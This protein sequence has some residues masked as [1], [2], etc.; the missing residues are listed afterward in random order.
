M[1]F[2][3]LNGGK[4]FRGI[5]LLE[6]SRLGDHRPEPA[7]QLAAGIELVHGYSLVHDDLPDMDDDDTRRGVEACHV[8]YDPHTAILCGNSLLSLAFDLYVD[9]GFPEPASKFTSPVKLLSKITGHNGVPRGQQKD[10]DFESG[11]PSRDDILRMYRQKTGKL[12]GFSMKIGALNAGLKPQ[13]ANEL[14]NIGEKLGVAYQIADDLLEPL[15]A[16]ERGERAGRSDREN[17][18]KTLLREIGREEAQQ[19]ARS[20]IRGSIDQIEALGLRTAQI[21]RL[22]KIVQERIP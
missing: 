17:D 14:Q 2:S 20:L 1:R 7:Y 12:I 5:L 11:D 9:Q 10:M 8:K 13:L 4:R 3:M 18:K 6:S 19:R 21:R 22:F 16:N 15:A